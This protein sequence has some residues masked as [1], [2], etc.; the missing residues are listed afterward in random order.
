MTRSIA[1]IF[2]SVLAFGQV[3]DAPAAEVVVNGKDLEGSVIGVTAKG[4]EFQTVY[5]EGTIVIAW[6]D[7]DGIRSDKEFLILLKDEETV[8]GRIWGVADNEL[9][10]GASSASAARIP[11]DRIYRSLTR[12]QY[13]QSLLDRLRVRYRYC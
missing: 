11:V 5:G 7:V 4:V 12:A 8:V 2:I 10:V 6:S 1:I 3:T 13:E 9:L